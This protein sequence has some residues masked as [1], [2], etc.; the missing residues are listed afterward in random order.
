MAALADGATG[1]GDVA[2]PASCEFVILDAAILR[3]DPARCHPHVIRD[4][5]RTDHEPLNM[6]GRE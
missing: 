4:G 1:R 5:K 2:E 6:Q 3:Y